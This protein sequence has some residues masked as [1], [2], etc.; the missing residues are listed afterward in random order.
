MIELKRAKKIQYADNWLLGKENKARE[1]NKY[2]IRFKKFLLNYKDLQPYVKKKKIPHILE[3]Q[4]RM[5]SIKAY[6]NKITRLLGKKNP[7][8]FSTKKASDLEEK[9]N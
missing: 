6:S 8:D 9:E 4:P 7:L 3:Y 1:Q 2:D 5:T